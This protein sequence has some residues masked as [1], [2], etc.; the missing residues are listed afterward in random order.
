MKW[1]RIRNAGEIEPQALHLVGASTKRNDSSKIGQFGSG[2]KYALAYL[3]RSGYAVRVFGGEKEILLETRAE[4]FRGQD[5]SVIYVGG[6]RTSITT[7]MGKDWQFWQA[8]REVYCNALDEG[9]CSMDFVQS[10]VPVVGE[11]HFYIDTKKDVLEFVGNFDNY[12]ATNKRVMFECKWGRILEKTGETAN[13]YR[14]GIRCYETKK[15]SVFDYD[16]PDLLIDENRLV[17]YNWTVEEKIWNLIFKCTDEKVIM[18]ILH[19]CNSSDY[20]EGCISDISTINSSGA[21]DVFKNCLKKIRIAP[22]GYAGLLKPDEVHQH[23][24]LPTKVFEAVRGEIGDENVG[25]N[26]KITRHGAIFRGEDMP[27]L[28]RATLKQAI[29]FFSE[30]GFDIPYDIEFAVF[31]DKD[32]FGSAVGD[33]IYLSDICFEKGVNEVTN[34]ILEEYIHL[35]YNVM[36]ET[37]AFQTA[38]LTEFISYMKKVNSF[39]I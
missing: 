7:D 33:K 21:S 12:F 8:I 3:L 6:E 37:R 34:T 20:L 35:K 31:D 29:Y 27:E 19:Q 15:T 14:K 22:K 10:V 26:F 38:M 13:V 23:V 9:G 11:T 2:N 25:D 4:S 39:V 16:I 5:F 30:T 32:I 17:K 36:D 1:I 24:I 28:Y 18:S